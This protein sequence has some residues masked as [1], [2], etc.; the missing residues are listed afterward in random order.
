M[1]VFRLVALAVLLFV[2]TS[3]AQRQFFATATAEAPIYA[4]Q[5]RAMNERAIE[6]IARGGSVRVLEERGN[7][8][9]VRTDAGNEGWVERRLLQQT[10]ARRAM[11]FDDVEIHGFLDNATPIFITDVEDGSTVEID[12]DRSFADALKRSADRE[13]HMRSVR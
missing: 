2:A 4:N 8:F 5:T 11:T 10:E 3:F 1:K 6:T 12:L 9:R 13:R 7:H